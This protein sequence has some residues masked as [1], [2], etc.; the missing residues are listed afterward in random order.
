[1]INITY[2]YLIENIDNDPYKVY[3]GKTINPKNR[4]LKHRQTYGDNLIYNIID[5][6]ESID[7]NKWEPLESYWIHQFKCWGFNI[8]NQN[9]GGGGPLKHSED[10]INK[11]KQI[12]CGKLQSEY[13]KQKRSRA[14]LGNKKDDITRNKMSQSSLSKP[15]TKEHAR[16]SQLARTGIPKPENFSS[17]ISKPIIQYDLQNNYI[18]EWKNITE[19]EK[20][21]NGDIGA[22]CRNKQLTSAGFIW[23]YKIS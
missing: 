5:S 9:E 11:M 10:T 1:M 13:T 23:K 17:K 20:Y 3:I 12:K 7:R 6:I 19:A 4:K 2:I 18:R 8:I 21:Y 15:K 16:N 22:C 14:L